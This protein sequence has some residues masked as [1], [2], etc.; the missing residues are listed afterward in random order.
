MNPQQPINKVIPDHAS[1]LILLG[2][3]RRKYPTC[4]VSKS[5]SLQL[6]PKMDKEELV[7]LNAFLG[8]ID[9]L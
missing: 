2:K 9:N 1:I 3:I 7:L 4:G 8:V 5:L 6:F